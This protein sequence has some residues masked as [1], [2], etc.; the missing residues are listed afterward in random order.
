MDIFKH[1][2]TSLFSHLKSNAPK[3]YLDDML[4]TSGN[5]FDS[6]LKYLEAILKVLKKVGVQVNAKKSAWFEMALEF[7]SFWVTQDGYQ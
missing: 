6:H 5:S 4:H 2:M 1:Q 3:I 7:I